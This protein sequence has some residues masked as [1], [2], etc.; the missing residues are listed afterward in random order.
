M[1]SGRAVE[2]GG[3][4]QVVPIEGADGG[5]ECDPGPATGTYDR[6]IECLQAGCRLDLVGDVLS[7]STGAE[8]PVA[9][10]VRTTDEIPP[11]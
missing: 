6:V 5:V 8:E 2:S 9:D 1:F 4:T 11:R 7:L 10:L 3:F